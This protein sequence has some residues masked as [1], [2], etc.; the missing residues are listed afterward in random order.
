[1]LIFNFHHVEP[2]PATPEPR[3]VERKH[4]TITPEGLRRFIRTLRA[5]GMQPA[6][7]REVLAEGGE[8]L[9]SDKTVLLTFDD[10]FENFL[11]HAAPVL[12]AEQ[13]PGTVFVLAG[14]FSGTNDWDQGD[15]EPARR[16]PLM[17]LAQMQDL[18]RYKM[19]TVGSHGMEHRD[20]TKLNAQELD[21][22]LNESYEILSRELSELF[23]PVLAYPYGYYSQ[24][25]LQA[26]EK[27]R[28]RYAVTT[29]KGDWTPASPRFEVPRYSIYYRDGNQLVFLAKLLRNGLLFSA[30]RF[31]ALSVAGVS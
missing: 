28:Y 21:R 29:G 19:V 16:D 11:L 5:L 23:V 24:T 31:K 2:D 4:I 26:M 15:R 20:L 27:T 8:R 30:P 1:M 12:E 17:S 14:K 25:V 18:S 22:E 6:S 9:L 7:L 10:G 13:C 3:H